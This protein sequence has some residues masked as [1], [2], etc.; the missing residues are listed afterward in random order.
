[1]Y[2]N[3]TLNNVTVDSVAVDSETVNGA[4][5]NS[6]AVN[7]TTVNVV[8]LIIAT[9]KSGNILNSA[10]IISVAVNGTYNRKIIIQ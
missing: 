2:S 6:A 9:A 1:M 3:T 4:A 10:S 7:S 8:L 5:D